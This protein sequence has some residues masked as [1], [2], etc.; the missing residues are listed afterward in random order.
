[1]KHHNQH[2]CNHN[3]PV[4]KYLLGFYI[5]MLILGS[6]YLLQA[7]N[8]IISPYV[9][10]AQFVGNA[11]P[12]SASG[13]ALLVKAKA[14]TA[15]QI[16]QQEEIE[17]YIKTIFGK[18]AKVA[19]AVS[20]H[21]CGPTNKAYPACNLHTNAEDSVGLFQINIQSKTAKVHFARIP[22]ETLEE[23][24]EWLKDPYN[25]TLLAYWIFQTSGWNPWS[26]YT[27]GRYL[28]SM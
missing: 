28:A 12:V 7:D 26:A 18:D 22:G 16:T 23:K 19:I 24:K 17:K 14:Q 6:A 15:G 13:S 4:G 25:N 3:K 27:S 5:L 9:A 2:N 1:M 8:S 10:Q 21:E 11:R 20:H